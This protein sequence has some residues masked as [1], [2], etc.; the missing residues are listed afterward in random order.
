[1]EIVNFI[2]GKG[3]LTSRSVY[4]DDFNP[5]ILDS[6]G[7]LLNTCIL[8]F[9]KMFNDDVTLV[10]NS[11]YLIKSTSVLVDV[12]IKANV[13]I[14]S[15]STS[16]RHRHMFYLYH[17]KKKGIIEKWD[18]LTWQKSKNNC[19]IYAGLCAIIRPITSFEKT[20]DLLRKIID[21]R[22]SSGALKLS[23]ITEHF[24]KYGQEKFI[25]D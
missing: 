10:D 14:N 18:P 22:N 19:V 25:Y 7:M 6:N 21:A 23:E 1:M 2:N 3:K 9:V 4:N 24:F 11:N 12:Q 8:R 13:D 5:D 16:T 20:K 15:T 17:N